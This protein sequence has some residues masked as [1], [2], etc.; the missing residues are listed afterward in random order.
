MVFLGADEA[1]VYV[2]DP[3]VGERAFPF[4]KADM[5][6][7]ALGKRAVYITERK[8]QDM[9]LKMIDHVS[10]NVLRPTDNSLKECDLEASQ[11]TKP[12]ELDE[13]GLPIGWVAPE[14]GDE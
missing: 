4:S 13:N 1:Q 2:F 7:N 6:Y 3:I 5:T 12:L 8:K 10:G 14:K 11:E 9:E